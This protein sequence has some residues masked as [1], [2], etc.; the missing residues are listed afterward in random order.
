MWKN[1]FPRIPSFKRTTGKRGLDVP[2][3]T[4]HSGN[5]VYSVAFSGDGTH[6]VSGSK[7]KS[8]WVWNASTGADFKTLN[9]HTEIVLSVAFSNDGTHIVSGSLDRSVRVGCLDGDGAQDPEGPH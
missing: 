8:V 1:Q 6:I 2:L 7:D 4:I 3:V 5:E 9:G